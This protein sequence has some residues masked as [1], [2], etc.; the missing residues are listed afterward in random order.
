M[1]RGAAAHR[2]L[3]GGQACP[4]IAAGALFHLLLVAAL[5]VIVYQMA[6]NLHLVSDE[7]LVNAEIH[8]ADGLDA[9][10]VE[11]LLERVTRKIREVGPEVSQIFIEPHPARRGCP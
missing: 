1:G 9:D 5:V 4:R 7:V 11:D 8:L 3:G 10:G 6:A 2:R